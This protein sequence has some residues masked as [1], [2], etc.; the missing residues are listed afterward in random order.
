MTYVLPELLQIVADA[1]G[2]D[3][4]IRLAALKGGRMVYIP[5]PDNDLDSDHWL[6][7]TIGHE[8]AKRIMELYGGTRVNIPLGPFAGNRSKVW[9]AIRAAKEQGIR[10][11]DTA[12]LVGVHHRT[13]RRHFN[14]QN[15]VK[16]MP[17]FEG[18]ENT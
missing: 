6:V 7:K 2:L 12:Q 16:S 8:A 1:A 18:L 15:R 10:P 9:A 14:K 11:F 4:A 3:A 13:V 5:V 17:L